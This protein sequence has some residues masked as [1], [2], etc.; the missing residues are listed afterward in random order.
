MQGQLHPI[1]EDDK[2][3]PFQVKQGLPKRS[4][5]ANGPV[6]PARVR[7]ADFP[8][9]DRRSPNGLHPQDSSFLLLTP[10]AALHPIPSAGAP[11]AL[12]LPARRCCA[13]PWRAEKQIQ[14]LRISGART[15]AIDPSLSRTHKRAETRQNCRK[16]RKT[17]A[18]PPNPLS[19]KTPSPR[20]PP[21]SPPFPQESAR[22]ILFLAPGAHPRAHER[23]LVA[24]LRAHTCTPL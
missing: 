1:R 6:S 23:D 24:R 11:A 20:S 15:K 5:R 10:R 9:A 4:P 7:S 2:A 17:P 3:A 22:K 12:T 19:R 18:T 8:N 14:N 21:V 16:L 13:K